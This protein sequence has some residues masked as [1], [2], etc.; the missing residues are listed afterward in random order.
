MANPQDG[1]GRAPLPHAE[2]LAQLLD[3]RQMVRGWKAIAAEL[4]VAERTARAAAARDFDP[5]P[6]Y[7]DD[8]NGGEVFMFRGAM[9]EWKL[10][11]I[12]PLHR[13]QAKRAARKAA[14]R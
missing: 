5:L 10:R 7:K 6:V 13:K 4:G 1:N 14:R 11:G 12:R 8:S 9:L 3:E 2:L